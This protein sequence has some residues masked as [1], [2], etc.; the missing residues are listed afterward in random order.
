LLL[1]RTEGDKA[2]EVIDAQVSLTVGNSP[3]DRLKYLKDFQD[4]QERLIK[5]LQKSFDCITEETWVEKFRV[6]A[7]DH[8]AMFYEDN[9]KWWARFRE[10][11]LLKVNGKVFDEIGYFEKFSEFTYEALKL[12]RVGA[13]RMEITMER[14]EWMIQAMKNTGFAPANQIKPA[15]ITNDLQRKIEEAVCKE[16]KTPIA[17]IKGILAHI[18]KEATRSDIESASGKAA[19]LPVRHNE[20][21]I[22]GGVGG[23]AMK[24]KGLAKEVG[25]AVE[26]PKGAIQLREGSLEAYNGTNWIH[27]TETEVRYL[28]ILNKQPG[29]W[30]QGR[31]LKAAPQSGER[32]DKIFVKLKKKLAGLIESSRDGYRLTLQQDPSE[33]RQRPV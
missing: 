30:V 22:L 28:K 23:E 7:T 31:C 11:V 15:A 27:V 14:P 18:K 20:E 12:L 16:L 21:N 17:E 9:Q 3:C 29:T 1:F 5:L 13:A 26:N 25:M 6:L 10:V 4:W 33:T 24:G 2:Q 19:G 32:P 8:K